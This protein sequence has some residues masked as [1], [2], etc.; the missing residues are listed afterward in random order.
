MMLARE[1]VTNTSRQK[2][3]ETEETYRKNKIKSSQQKA[4]KEATRETR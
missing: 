4:E 3:L 1:E 2:L